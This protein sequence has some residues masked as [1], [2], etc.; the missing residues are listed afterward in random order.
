MVF[1]WVMAG[2]F[3]GWLIPS[4]LHE[5]NGGVKYFIFLTNWCYLGWCSYLIISAIS[6]TLKISLV[7]FCKNQSL[8]DTSTLLDNP[9]PY[10]DIDK[11]VGCCG[12]ENDATSWYQKIQWLFFYLGAEMAV[13]VSILY[14]AII[15][16][17]SDV[18]DGVNVN[19]HLVNGI[20]AFFDICVSG[21]PIRFLHIIYPVLFGVC[22][23]VFSGIYF[24]AGGTNVDDDPFIYSVLDYENH[25]GTATVWVLITVLVFI[26]LLH[27]L[28]YGVYTVRFWLTYC[29]W[30]K[31][32]SAEETMELTIK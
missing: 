23:G 11:P 32:E 16:S 2:Y 9:H 21:I 28:M 19:T 4:G 13:I 10:I 25:P 7:Y 30:A 24:A 22:Y 17:S 26:P 3:F 6:A 18:L 29:L 27:L 14:W 20:I 1:R 15:Y 5:L 12:Q 8:R 31:R